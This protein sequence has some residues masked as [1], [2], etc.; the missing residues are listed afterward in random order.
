MTKLAGFGAA[1]VVVA[2]GIATAAPPVRSVSQVDAQRWAGTWYELARV[3]NGLQA[4]CIADATATYLPRADGSLRVIQRC[5]DADSRWYVA[6]ARAVS[7]DNDHSGA[8]RLRLSYL[9]DWLA[10][11]PAAS[12]DQWVVML[13]GNYRYAVVS[14]P[15]RKHLW[16]LSRTPDI[17][18]VTYDRILANLRS[19]HFPVDQLIPTPQLAQRQAP[20]SAYGPR[21][22]V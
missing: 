18:S 3:P 2:L 16:I 21:L 8:A 19:A 13:D 7:A 15:T 17:D 22:M 10:W 1:T 9:P 14:E 11:L 6:T 5:R 12:G 4:R 20:A